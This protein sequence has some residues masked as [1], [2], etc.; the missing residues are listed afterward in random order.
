MPKSS[1]KN[2]WTLAAT[3]IFATGGIVGWPLLYLAPALRFVFEKLFTYG[4]V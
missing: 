2:H 3:L 4:A 1:Q